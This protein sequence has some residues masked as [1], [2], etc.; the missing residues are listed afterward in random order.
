MPVCHN[1]DTI[2]TVVKVISIG[3]ITAGEISSPGG[4]QCAQ[5]T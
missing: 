4:E 5:G 2:G 1:A 3:A